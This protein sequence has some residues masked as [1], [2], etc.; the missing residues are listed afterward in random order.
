MYQGALVAIR[1]HLDWSTCSILIW[2][3]VAV[4]HTG[5]RSP[6]WD[7]SAACTAAVHSWCI[8]IYIYICSYFWY[9]PTL[10][11]SMPISF[12]PDRYESTSWAVYQGSPQDNGHYRPTWLAHP[13][14]ELV[15]LCSAVSRPEVPCTS[16]SN[17]YNV[18]QF[19]QHPP[20]SPFHST[21]QGRK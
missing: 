17:I 14:T 16:G 1:R 5:Q 20:P 7:G 4:L 13:R 15:G 11:V 18:C 21:V 19:Y 8:Y 3:R 10:S 12:S 9:V 6:S 2:E